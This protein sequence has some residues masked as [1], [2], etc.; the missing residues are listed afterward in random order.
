VLWYAD[1][2]QVTCWQVNIIIESHKKQ[3]PILKGEIIAENRK[4][5]VEYIK[6]AL[7]AA[8]DYTIEQVYE[9]LLSTEY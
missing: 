5:M 2:K 4:E 7:M 1:V 8:D 3:V 9:F 6:E